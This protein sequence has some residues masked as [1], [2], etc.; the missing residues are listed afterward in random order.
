MI[1]C[2]AVEPVLDH[3]LF[4]KAIVD[5]GERAKKI[6]RYLDILQQSKDGVPLA[7]VN[8]LDQ[9]IQL[10]FELVLSNNFDPWDI[11]LIE[12]T[13]LYTKKMKEE[14]VNFII[15]GKLVFMAWAI[16]RLQS[17]KVLV[18]HE[19]LEGE[20]IFCSDWD[21]DNLDAFRE[22]PALLGDFCDLPESVELTEVVRHRGSRPVSLVEL[23][24]AFDEARKEAEANVQRQLLREAMKKAQ[25]VFDEKAH[26]E[27]LEKDVENVW[28]RIQHCGPGAIRI[29]DIYNCSKEDRV[30]VFVSLLFLAKMGK[31][32]LWQD[33]F[34]FGQILLE[35]KVSWDIGTLEDAAAPQVEVVGTELASGRMVI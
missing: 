34:P 12:F 10:V 7:S 31:I 23:L 25:G 26:A 2:A 24:D 3:L 27:D 13:R 4:H 8:P 17:E 29:E 9:S 1:E 30:M 20:G 28:I 5:E 32:S 11:D 19:Q 18:T 16:L 35:V 22:E 33:D 21:F 6:D 15:A 14:E